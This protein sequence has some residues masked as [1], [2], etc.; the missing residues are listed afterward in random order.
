MKDKRAYLSEVR[1][2]AGRRGAE[3]RWAGH[4]PKIVDLSNLSDTNRRLVVD[5]VKMLQG[6]A[7]VS[8]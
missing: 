6:Q 2:E 5:I 8:K 1:A 3:A 7:K 4:A